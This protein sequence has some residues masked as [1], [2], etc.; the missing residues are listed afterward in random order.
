MKDIM[1]DIETLGT[2][3]N[4]VVT[5][6]GAIYFNRY[7]GELGKELLVNIQIQD[8][9]NKGLQVDAGSIKFWFEQPERSFL[10]RPTTLMDA[11][12]QLRDFHNIDNKA[13]VWAHSTFDFPIL[14]NAYRKV[15]Q[16]F[17]FP[18][19]NLRDIRTLVDLSGIKYKKGSSGDPKTHNALDD[20]KHQVKYCTE[21]FNKIYEKTK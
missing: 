17:C 12:Q 10:D 8:C 20:C 15:G 1:V 21:A 11:L 3:N 14:H 4:S 9:L 5:Q 2:A 7:T 13:L 19:R 18:Y 16:G 6:I